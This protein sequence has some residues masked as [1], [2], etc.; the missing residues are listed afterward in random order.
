MTLTALLQHTPG[1]VWGLLAALTAVGVSQ[2]RD[3]QVSLTRV[4]VLPLAMVALSFIGMFHVFGPTPI[5]LSA[6]AAGV[7]TALTLGRSAVAVRGASWSEAAARLHVPGSWLP[8]A[9]I[10]ALFCIKYGVGYETAM[11]PAMMHEAG[12]SAIIGFAYG[13][14]SGLFL[15]RGLSLRQVVAS[16]NAAAERAAA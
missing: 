12:F 1:Y 16:R 9:L 14:F 10:L 3:R 15:A 13:L 2:A 11:H 6:W 5:A 7:A 4:T 8:L